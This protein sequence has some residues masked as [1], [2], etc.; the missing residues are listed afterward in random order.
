[1]APPRRT[2]RTPAPGTASFARAAGATFADASNGRRPQISANWGLAMPTAA[3]KVAAATAKG[4]SAGLRVPVGRR[5]ALRT[6]QYQTAI[7]TRQHANYLSGTAAR[8]PG[9][10]AY[11]TERGDAFGERLYAKQTPTQRARGVGTW[12][13]S[14]RTCM[15]PVATQKGYGV[16]T[17]VEPRPG[18]A[19]YTPDDN[20]VYGRKSS[21]FDG[22]QRGTVARDRRPLAPFEDA[23]E[24]WFVHAP[25][26]PGHT[27]TSSNHKVPG[28]GR[29]QLH[30]SFTTFGAQ[31]ETRLQ[32]PF[33]QAFRPTDKD[34]PPGQTTAVV[35]LYKEEF[36]FWGDYN[37]GT[38]G[39]TYA[40]NMMPV[41][42]E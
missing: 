36:I 31:S 3:L 17:S 15:A 8:T 20:A 35:K 24:R 40:P 29:H 18:P 27:T 11:R 13:T 2:R 14:D 39:T 25:V 16:G 37:P 22:A 1:M 28:V 33:S 10:G 34:V 19:S 7:E 4:E 41:R 6:S 42:G 26:A 32:P 23:A 12:G 38:D 9:A 30:P 21:T 5:R